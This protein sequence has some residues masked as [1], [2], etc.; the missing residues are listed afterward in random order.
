MTQRSRNLIMW[1]LY[2]LLFLA[3]LLVQTV[4]FGRMRFFGVKLNLMPVVIV[5]VGLWTGH[6]A[7]GLFG[8]LAAL[9][10]FLTGADDGSLSIVSFTLSGILAGWACDNLFRRRLFPCLVLCLAAL[11]AHEGVLFLLKFF[12]KLP[13]IRPAKMMTRN[14]RTF[15]DIFTRFPP[16][17]GISL[18]ITM[19]VR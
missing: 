19:S 15:S 6:E 11:L 9:A 17:T 1:G 16:N 5:C 18:L 14:T 12:R 13:K 2:A 8:L 3:V 7:G 10:W 4:V